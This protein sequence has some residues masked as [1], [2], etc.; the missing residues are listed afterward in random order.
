MPASSWFVA[1]TMSRGP[2][3]LTPN[4]LCHRWIILS[5]WEPRAAGIGRE[6][7]LWP[8]SGL[9]KPHPSE[10]GEEGTSAGPWAVKRPMRCPLSGPQAMWRL[11]G[12]SCADPLD[13]PSP[14]PLDLCTQEQDQ[15]SQLPPR[16]GMV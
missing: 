4:R 9:A 8:P 16:M 3:P 2:M 5:P 15:L 14:A 13:W 12:G 10:L 11:A 6:K 7:L 1:A